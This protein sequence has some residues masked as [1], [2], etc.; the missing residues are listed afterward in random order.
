MPSIKIK[1]ICIGND[2]R[3]LIPSCPISMH[4]CHGHGPQV[5]LQVKKCP[6]APGGGLD[7]LQGSCGC[8]VPVIEKSPEGGPGRLRLPQHD[9]RLAP[10]AR[11]GEHFGGEALHKRLVLS[12]AGQPRPGRIAGKVG[13]GA[14][15]VDGVICG[16][17]G[18][19]GVV[20]LEAVEGPEGGDVGLILGREGG[21]TVGKPHALDTF[22]YRHG[23]RADFRLEAQDEVLSE[24]RII[25]H[26]ISLGI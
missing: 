23:R 7:P 17:V 8:K 2:L 19:S 11:R 26:E 24:T 6:S 18:T 4:G 21:I 3:L 5:Q 16:A 12:V 22:V 1:E 25:F 20:S 15:S 13:G 10:V 14:V 9:G